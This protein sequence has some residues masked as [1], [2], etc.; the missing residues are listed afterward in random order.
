VKGWDEVSNS[1]IY[2]NVIESFNDE[3]FKIRSKGG[4]LLEGRYDKLATIAL[5]AKLHI[6]VTGVDAN[7]DTIILELKGKNYFELNEVLKD[8]PKAIKFDRVEDGKVGAVKFKS[9]FFVAA[10]TIPVP[11]AAEEISVVDLPF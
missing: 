3:P 1:A 8:E 7:G 5:G 6:Q 9:P 11:V 4:T 10:N 2:S